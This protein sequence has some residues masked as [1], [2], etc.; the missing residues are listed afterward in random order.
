[1]GGG[2]ATAVPSTL[3]PC[4][5]DLTG[6]VFT[7]T[8]NCTT[9][10]PIVVPSTITTVSGGASKLTINA[11]D[12]GVAGSLNGGVLQSTPGA[13]LNVENLNIAGSGFISPPACGRAMLFGIWFDD[14]SGSVSNVTITGI[15]EHSGC[16]PNVGIG[17]R[18]DGITAPRTVNI[19][20]TTVTGYMR[21]GLDARCSMT[22]NVSDST[23]GPPENPA[24][25]GQ[26]GIV[27]SNAAT[28][29]SGGSPSGSV[30]NST[31]YGSGANRFNNSTEAIIMQG[32]K[33]V[34]I[35]DNKITSNPAQADGPDIGIWVLSGGGGTPSTGIVISFNHV[36]RL[37]PDS[38]DFD[39]IGIVVCSLPAAVRA[40]PVP[41]T[42]LA[43]EC[44]P[45]V[46]PSSATL[47]CN[48]FAG[49]PTNILGALQLG[50]TPFPDPPCGQPYSASVL[51]VQGGG[52]PPYKWSAV[53]PLPPG[54]SM[55][56]SGTVSGTPTEAGTFHFTATVVD[57]SAPPLTASQPG[58]IT[59]V[60]SCSEEAGENPAIPEADEP[61]EAPV[62]PITT[63]GLAFT[64]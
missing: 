51:S 48:T 44:F 31:I 11:S 23:I 19:T 59:V 28:D 5:G 35:T 36:E 17:I 39:G 57:S 54:L 10:A 13:T 56:S 47:I 9:T 33:N 6:G 1:M 42:G 38:P 63:T 24:T 7:L 4:A 52:E 22:M 18:A 43:D 41:A 14:S 32:A 62:A 20:G 26:N 49:W 12:G 2:A 53:D 50:C 27:Y 8:V 58:S 37:T 45:A 61:G 25:L 46:P 21:N 60:G 64:G 29:C 34:T 3:G 30:A 16:P 40:I 55:A 15:T